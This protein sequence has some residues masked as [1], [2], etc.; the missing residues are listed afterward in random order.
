M[1]SWI[2]KNVGLAVGLDIE[3]RIGL[4]GILSPCI[5]R[6]DCGDRICERLDCRSVELKLYKRSTSWTLTQHYSDGRMDKLDFGGRQGIALVL[7]SNNL[8]Y[9]VGRGVF[10]LYRFAI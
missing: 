2:L 6:L 10:D 1:S 7:A 9:L 8:G 3:L 4:Y 5:L